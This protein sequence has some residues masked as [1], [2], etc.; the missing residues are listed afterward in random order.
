MKQLLAVIILGVFAVTI[1]LPEEANAAQT[2]VLL[3]GLARTSN[4]MAK[5]DVRLQA[6]G[7]STCNIGYPSTR[8]SI[9]LLAKNYVLPKVKECLEKQRGSVSFVTHS[10]GGIVVREL[11]RLDPE[12][13]IARVVMLGPPNHGSELTDHMRSWPLYQ[14]INGPAG[15]QLGTDAE[16]APNSL[17]PA[18]FELGIIAGNK[19][20]LEPFTGYINGPSDGKVSVESTKLNGMA[21]H[22]VLP[23]THALMMRNDEVIQQTIMFLQQG[24]FADIH[25]GAGK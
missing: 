16:S 12:L 14:W 4:S 23:V 7:Y 1:I 21:A 2:V 13:P 24:I 20:L 8:H 3:H 9:Q 18:D 11:R 25:T 17:G 5:M 10:L 15:Q 19:P 22:I 6:A